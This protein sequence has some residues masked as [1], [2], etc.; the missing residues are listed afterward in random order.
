MPANHDALTKYRPTAGSQVVFIE[1]SLDDAVAM[2]D[3]DDEKPKLA[4]TADQAN[5]LLNDAEPAGIR[6]IRHALQGIGHGHHNF[7]SEYLND[8]S[9]EALEKV[10]N[11]DPAEPTP[12]G[13][14]NTMADN[15][16]SKTGRTTPT[17]SSSRHR[18]R[19]RKSWPPSSTPSPT[20]WSSNSTR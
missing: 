10:V 14:N 8:I 13:V 20:P 15:N 19:T 6:Q 7:F 2:F 4:A 1:F 9:R 16:C 12:A 3:A 17:R 11:L 5:Q 18:S